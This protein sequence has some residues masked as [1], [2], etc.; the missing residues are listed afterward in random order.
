[1]VVRTR[2]VVCLVRA[3]VFFWG[4]VFCLIPPRYFGGFGAF[5][6][7]V[8]LYSNSLITEDLSAQID[9]LLASQPGIQHV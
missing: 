7:M 8:T 4:C 6:C 3:F 9:S 1:M 2:M 5:F